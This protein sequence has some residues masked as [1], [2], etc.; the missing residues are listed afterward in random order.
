MTRCAHHLNHVGGESNTIMDVNA[1]AHLEMVDPARQKSPSEGRPFPGGSRGRPTQADSAIWLGS[2]YW[3]A[4][5]CAA[6]CSATLAARPSGLPRELPG[7][8]AEATAASQFKDTN[9]CLVP[10]PP[11]LGGGWAV[12]SC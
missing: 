6:C 5:C 7:E 12:R 10:E 11:L 4:A 2:L 8:V 9:V 3:A 1:N